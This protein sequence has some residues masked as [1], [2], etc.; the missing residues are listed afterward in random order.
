MGRVG[1]VGVCANAGEEMPI[2]SASADVVKI[3]VGLNF[4]KVTSL[5]EQTPAGCMEGRHKE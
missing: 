2:V 5:Q 1:A 4:M 3:N